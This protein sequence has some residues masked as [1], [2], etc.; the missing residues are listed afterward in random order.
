MH[1]TLIVL[2]CTA[3]VVC[4]AEPAKSVAGVEA[5]FVAAADGTA[6]LYT[7]DG[8]LAA[9]ATIQLQYPAAG[10]AVQC[11][12]RLQGDALE[13]PDTSTEPV[14]DALFGNPVFRYR[15]KQLPAALKGDPFIGTAVIGTRT[16][17][18]DPASAGTMLRIGT[19]SGNAPRVQTCLG[20]EG[21]NLFL[22]ADGKL[23]SQ[24]YYAFGYDVSATCNPGLFDLP[25]AQ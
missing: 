17:H 1:R 8:R 11:C 5:G 24:L 23:Q 4:A 13:A 10:G 19:A 20:S 9:T 15:L 22:I 2:A 18:A 14:T 21:S 3:A 7:T 16:V 12:L 25:T 6:W